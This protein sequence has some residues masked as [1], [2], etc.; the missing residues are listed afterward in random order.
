MKKRILSFLLMLC[1]MASLIPVAL[2]PASAADD[3]AQSGGAG[4]SQ[5]GPASYTDLYVGVGGEATVNGGILT[6]L[7]T[8][9]QS[10]STVDLLNSAWTNTAAGATKHATLG[11]TW[12]AY[13]KGGIGYDL[14]TFDENYLLSMDASLLPTDTYT[15]EIVSSVRGVTENADGVT[16]FNK[17]STIANISLGRFRS[18]LFCGPL[19]TADPYHSRYGNSLVTMYTESIDSA[20]DD[21]Y[22]TGALSNQ[23]GS[24]L[25]LYR[26][27]P[28]TQ[29]LTI[30][31]TETTTKYEYKFQHNGTDITPG[32]RGCTKGE[33]PYVGSFIINRAMP[34]TYYAVR[35]Y[36]KP[37]TDTELAQNR[38]VDILLHADI[39]F[40]VYQS[41]HDDDK[42]TFLNLV[43]EKDFAL[44]AEDVNAIVTEL[45]AIRAIEKEA[46]KKTAYDAL[47]VGADGSKTENGG[48]LSILLSAYDTSSVIVHEKSTVWYDKM[49]NYNATLAGSLWQKYADGGIGYDLSAFDYSQYL[50]IDP[51]ALP[52]DTYTLEYV[53]SVR[54]I[55]QNADGVT[56]YNVYG[57]TASISLG[58]FRGFLFCGPLGTKDPYHTRYGN[59][60][61]TMYSEASTTATDDYSTTGSA[62]GH[63]NTR[64]D[65]Y[66]LDTDVISLAITLTETDTKYKY[67][68]TKNGYD[69]TPTTSGCAKGD[70]AYV[71][72]FI[73]NRSMPATIYAMRLYTKPLTEAELATN[74]FIDLLAYTGTAITEYTNMDAETRAFVVDALKETAFVDKA[75]FDKALDNVL[76]LVVSKWDAESS[77]Y[78]TD[79][80]EVLLASYD[81]F[82]TSTRFDETKVIWTNAVKNATFGTLVGKG[83]YRN[84]DGGIRIRETI[85]QL[86]LAN[87]KVEAYRTAQKN[88]YYINFDYSYLPEGEFTIE[89][90]YDPEG[91]TVED[92]EGNITLLYDD[93]S[94]YGIYTDRMMVIG[95]YRTIGWVCDTKSEGA[96]DLQHRWL[97]QESQCWNDRTDATRVKV[98]RDYGVGPVLNAGIVNYT[99]EHDIFEEVDND[100]IIAT[101]TTSHNG[102]RGLLSEISA[103]IYMTKDKVVDQVFDMWRGM[104][105][106]HYSI[107]I[108]NRLLSEEE[109]IQ[110]HVADIC[111]YFDLDISMLV[112]TLSK[113]PDKAT[114]FKAFAHLS[115]NM[116]KEEAQKELD[117]GMAGIWV[118]YDGAAVKQDMS[119]AIRFYFSLRQASITAIMQAGFAVELGTLVNLS[120]EMPDLTEGEYDYRFVAFDSVAGA[121]KQYF[122]DEDTYAVTLSYQDGNI[123]LYNQKLKVV[124]YV[125]LT[126]AN[127]EEM[128]FYGGFAGKEYG[129]MTSFFTLMHYFDSIEI[130]DDSAVAGYISDAV[131]SCYYDKTVYFDSHA[132]G[133][134]DGSKEKPYT[135][136]S[137]AFEACNNALVSLDRPT[138]VRLFV[139]GGTHAISEILEFD[140]DEITYPY[141]Y[142]TIEGDYLA[143]EIPE[144]TT[145]VGLSSSDFEA[146]AGKSGLYVYEFAPD[147]NG[148]YP[149]FRNLYVDGVTATRSHTTPT[150]TSRGERPLTFAYDRD[151]PGTYHLAQFYYLKGTLS[152]HAPEVEYQDRPERTDLIESYTVHYLWFLALTDLRAAYNA[153]DKA[154]FTALTAE[155][156]RSGMGEEYAAAVAYFKDDFIKAYSGSVKVANITYEAPTFTEEERLGRFYVHM[157]T[158]E[159]LR[160]L[161]E[162][163]LADLKANKEYWLSEVAR[164]EALLADK[165]AA[166]AAAKTDYEEKLAAAGKADATDEE[167][168]A[169]IAAKAVMEAA[170]APVAEAKAYLEDAKWRVYNDTSYKIATRGLNIELHVAANWCF[171]IMDIDGIDYDDITYYYDERHNKVET[172]VAVYL[173]ESQ[174]EHFQIPPNY[175]TEDRLY[176]VQN[177]L[178]FVDEEGEYYYDENEGK[179]YYYTEYDIEELSFSRPTLDNIFVFENTN[180][181]ILA[182]LTFWGVDNFD[183]S[184]YGIASNQGGGN[185][186]VQEK[187]YVISFT[188][189]SVFTSWD[190]SNTVIRDCYFHD[191]A[192]AAIYMEGRTE[193]VTISGNEFEE[194][195]AHTINIAPVPGVP[196]GSPEYSER[197]GAEGILITE[198]Y[199]HEVSTESYAAPAITMPSTKDA[200]LSYNTIIG[201]SYTGI[202]I[203]WYYSPGTWEEHERYNLYNVNIHHNYIT[204]F[205]REL[206]DGGAIYVLGGNLKPD[207][208]K[209]V[210]FC[211]HNFVVMSKYTGNGMN[212]LTNGYYYDGASSNWSNYNNIC[213]NYSEG[214]DRGK[215]A[216]AS[217][218]D[219][220]HYMSMKGSNLM[221]KQNHPQA[222]SYNIHSWNN[223][224]YNVRAK[225]G[226]EQQ[227]EVFHMHTSWKEHGH[228]IRDCSY[229]YGSNKLAFSN[230]IKALIEECGSR[231]RPGEWE[232]LLGNDY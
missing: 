186:I 27:N 21:Y 7:M 153:N 129:D 142:Y 225:T 201:C 93:Y 89:S 62:S 206:G 87:K 111:Y 126:M 25:D 75:E 32:A 86:S 51:T 101:Y 35:L 53:S 84:E 159:G 29:S 23:W 19:G 227:N 172:L 20:S 115:F 50:S 1:M 130:T 212:E 67:S 145:V 167:K 69:I 3:G 107:R 49:G 10:A 116:T 106:T 44:T 77:L 185:K 219:Y 221:F 218:A 56:S 133:V 6:V 46:S 79:G 64:I 98:G 15:L 131:D 195:G 117:N 228:I 48:V 137:D 114:V 151:I 216:G 163:R 198:N 173:N 124:T 80:L 63:W 160:E 18:F 175:Y 178:C 12:T 8:A 121:H 157:E 83:W 199:I 141:Y 31:L 182:D 148:K 85:P 61:V 110:N 33:Q 188:R 43:A 229:F 37:L 94:R 202:S 135:D 128:V 174:Y 82:S 105:A 136:F 152:E 217:D 177:A 205:M 223:Y 190:T 11:G 193:N 176:S 138:N 171:N 41:V 210:N 73:I 179:L 17:F 72:S 209:Q 5:G 204:D 108:Y 70:S 140:F 192:A 95:P 22:V 103:E 42:K 55:T 65:A 78:V 47:Y 68:F 104:A 13:E 183:L 180:N 189:K 181:F 213:V 30:T 127:G 102:K 197:S 169:Y 200:E 66:R 230:N 184:I 146:V 36:T 92:A 166:Y 155:D 96:Y 76:G 132:D 125:R 97:Y 99:I 24:R 109:K 9:Y 158:V 120:E 58:R 222:I 220:H 170:E 71:G 26:E 139:E 191:L 88:E 150:T 90:I 143:E 91:L 16:T 4:A 207:N 81:G 162:E 226:A 112:D 203:G 100:G 45:A 60:I 119:D 208:P 38:A 74:H 118:G 214:A 196:G 54:G 52:T 122:L 231:M 57:Q 14:A 147:E 123:D 164:R 232:W 144:L 154:T 28:T 211:H 34:A 2:F 224:F 194:I 149:E 215:L 59:S 165:E 161:V 168:I 113:I 187:D 39:P 40:S 156:I 134:G